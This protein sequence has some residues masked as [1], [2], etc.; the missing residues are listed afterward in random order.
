MNLICEALADKHVVSVCRMQLQLSFA[1]SSC[2]SE[3]LVR[4]SMQGV[5]GD[6]SVTVTV[7]A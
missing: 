5:M 1:Q 7:R 3:D 6:R 4:Y 2:P